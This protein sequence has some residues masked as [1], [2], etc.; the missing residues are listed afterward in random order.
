MTL[1][2]LL[3]EKSMAAFLEGLLPRVLP[4][5]VQYR[6]IPHEG[7]SDLE[8]SIPRKLR[9]WKAP[10]TRFVVVRDQDS[11]DCKEVKAK[12]RA[13]CTEGQRPDTLVRIACRE[14]EAWFLGEMNAVSAA[15]GSPTLARH[16]GAG[17]FADPDHLGSP[18]KE[19]VQLVPSYQKVSGARRIGEHFDP[20]RCGS[21]SF[22]VFH[23][24]LLRLTTPGP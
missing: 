3:E 1:V 4:E 19:L 2:L 13:L 8:R 24:G 6:L 17:K 23:S 5:G 18:S 11:G 10:D 7:K 15:F 21:Q 20:A 12:L 22:Q 14:L 9:G 16:Q